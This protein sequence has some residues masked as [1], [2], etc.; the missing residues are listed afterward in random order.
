MKKVDIRQYTESDW[1]ALVSLTE[2]LQDFLVGIDPLRRLLRKPEYGE[3]Y[4]THV[5][6]DAAQNCGKVLLAILDGEVVGYIAGIIDLESLDAGMGYVPT[7]A[8]RITELVVKPAMRSGGLGAQL[9]AA[10]EMF[11]LD[12]RCNII[13]VEVFAPNARAVKFYERMG[14]GIRSLDMVRVLPDFTAA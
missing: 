9:I 4:T 12:S 8:G 5:L 1:G 2:E 6:S 3:R 14:Y 7:K 13:R 10:I 11:F